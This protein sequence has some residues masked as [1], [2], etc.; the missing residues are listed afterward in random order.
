MHE[1]ESRCMNQPTTL[2][3]TKISMSFRENGLGK[4][5]KDLEKEETEQLA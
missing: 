3:P 4:D 2:I 1:T 5:E